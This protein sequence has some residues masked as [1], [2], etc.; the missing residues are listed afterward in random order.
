MIANC[1]RS[2]T[3][4]SAEIPAAVVAF[5]ASVVSF[6]LSRWEHVRSIRPS[7]LL[8]LYLIVALIVQAVH[9]RTI[10]TI[11]DD[12]VL[13]ALGI[14][15]VASCAAFLAAESAGKERVLITKQ[16]RS[17]QDV[18]DL[19]SERMFWWLNNLFTRGYRKI[20]APGDLDQTDE[21]LSSPEID[22]RFRL[23]WLKC[24]HRDPKVSLIRI[25]FSAMKYDMLFP[26]IPRSL[27]LAISFA[28]P[29]LILRFV[30]YL[31]TP[32]EGGTE[33]GILLVLATA[34]T[35]T[36]LA[37]FQGWYW[38]S[39]GRF[40]VKLRG[41]LTVVLHDRALRSRPSSDSS[42][43][44][45]MNVDVER[46]LTGLKW[47]HEYWSTVVTVAIT[48]PLLYL[49]VG[50][51]FFAPLVLLGVLVTISTLNGA[52]VGPKQHFWFSATQDRI[53]YITDVIASMKNIKLLGITKSVLDRGTTLREREVNAQSSMRGS[54]LL[55]TA[56][57]LSNY[58]LA[59]LV[60]YSA[61]AIR[62]HLGGEP[63]T[64]TRLFTSL[65]ILKL[66][67]SPMITAI[68]S[69]PSML[70]SISSLQRIQDYL[71]SNDHVDQR[72]I[73]D[74]GLPN[75]Y[76]IEGVVKGVY[77]VCAAQLRDVTCGYSRD[78]AVLA[79]VSCGFPVGGLHV[80]SGP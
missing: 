7:K 54:L 29:Y 2:E 72:H 69:V 74:E 47:T 33:E 24:Y 77:S 35:Y 51:V 49:Q 14:G 12:T 71:A 63:L 73:N 67:T 39:V 32:A 44:T 76:H 66:F 75:G 59:T 56:I 37:I 65:S 6:A 19:F 8:Q 15:Q 28:Q 36:A 58:Q 4:N 18:N 23:T 31:E 21:D 60:L 3:T 22:R 9:L 42:P 80:V 46:V 25:V 53:S 68:Q 17:P 26:I 55:N 50:I 64:N 52:S 45:L 16:R 11:H 20:L 48:L 1:V 57:S 5:L 61:Y 78:V 27:L 40:L 70:Q 79:N 62:T 30:S 43:L 10:W 34:T 38:Q 13:Q 41:C